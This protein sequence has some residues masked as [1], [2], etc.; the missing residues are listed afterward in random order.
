[1]AAVAFANSVRDACPAC[2]WAS[3]AADDRIRRRWRPPRLPFDPPGAPRPLRFPCFGGR[4]ER[5]SG[6]WGISRPGERRPANICRFRIRNGEKRDPGPPGSRWIHRESGVKAHGGARRPPRRTRRGSLPRSPRVVHRERPP[7]LFAHAEFP[8]SEMPS[9]PPPCC[10]SRNFREKR[11]SRPGARWIHHGAKQIL[12]PRRTRRSNRPR[13]PPARR[14]SAEA[15][16]EG[17]AESPDRTANRRAALRRAD[18][19]F[20]KNAF[21]P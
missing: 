12:P 21:P 19:F 7:E 15:A 10:A 20:G 6:A 11:V 4:G 1:M 17:G 14:G 8:A 13:Q 3:G 5:V 18:S 16:H 9:P 2:A